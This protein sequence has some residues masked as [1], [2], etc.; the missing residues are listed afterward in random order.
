MMAA[1]AGPAS[2]LLGECEWMTCRFS[3]PAR[4]FAGVPAFARPGSAGAAGWL[5]GVLAAGRLGGVD[6]PGWL[7]DVQGFV[8]HAPPPPGCDGPPLGVD[9]TPTGVGDPALANPDNGT[10][11]HKSSKLNSGEPAR[12]LC[13]T[14][15]C[16]PPAVPGHLT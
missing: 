8:M 16:R 14:V 12:A 13:R 15:I 11:M 3:F 2:E 5:G 7:G 1:V 6:I 10:R 9:G 4:C